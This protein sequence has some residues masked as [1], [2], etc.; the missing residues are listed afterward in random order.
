MELLLMYKQ[1]HIFAMTDGHKIAATTYFPGN[2]KEIIGHF[3]ILHGMAEHQRRYEGFANYLNEL[4]YL[5]TTHDH[6]GH[7]DT[8]EENGGL[9]G[10]FADYDGFERVVQDVH[11][12]LHQLREQHGVY[13]LTIFGHSMGSFIAR[14]YAQH[15]SSELERV[16]YCATGATTALHVAG[17]QIAKMLCRVQ[18]AKTPSRIMNKLSFGSFNKNIAKAVTNFDWLC[19]DEQVVKKYIEDTQCA[20]IATNQFFV[21]LTGGLITIANPKEIKKVRADLPILFISGSDDP[22][23]ESGKGV[24]KVASRYEQAGMKDVT[25][26]MFEGMRHEILNERNKQQVYDVVTRWMNNEK[27]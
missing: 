15:Y 16:I 19:T 2:E 14:R 25:V 17:N 22:V 10:Y 21:D 18:G 7:G 12:V 20:F 9:F 11:E 8:A 4:G 23:G 26:Y 27:I 24:Y 6:R 13:P 5:V 3:H 1:N